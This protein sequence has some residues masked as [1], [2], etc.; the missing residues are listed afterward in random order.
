MSPEFINPNLA[1]VI[2]ANQEKLNSMAQAAEE[3]SKTGKLEGFAKTAKSTVKNIA[4]S[5]FMRQSLPTFF[6]QGDYLPKFF[7]NALVGRA[8][9]LRGAGYIAAASLAIKT[10]GAL[11]HSI[12]W[13]R[14]ARNSGPMGGYGPGYL[15]WSKRSGLAS[16][17]LATD[18]LSLALHKMRHTSGV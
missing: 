15:S 14:P 16:N 4:E 11:W 9:W 10:V 17:H 2:R 7:K 6:R 3:L 12:K 1:N 18:G 13:S 8:G 5:N